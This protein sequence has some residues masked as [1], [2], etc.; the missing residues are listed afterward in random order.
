MTSQCSPPDKCRLPD[1]LT[2]I[3]AGPLSGF[4]GS[5]GHQRRTGL[6]LPNRSAIV[7]LLGAALGIDGDNRSGQEGIAAYGVAVQSLRRSSALR[8]F[9]TVQTI[10]AGVATG[11]KTRT[12]ALC[13]AGEARHNVVTLRDYRSDTAIGVAVWGCGGWALGDLAEA[14][15]RPVYALSLGRRSCPPSWPLDPKIISAS[16]PVA[17]LARVKPA[18]PPESTAG[19]GVERGAV[20][21][22]SAI[23]GR[24]ASRSVEL[25][26]R[27]ENRRTWT[28]LPETAWIYPPLPE[29]CD[30]Q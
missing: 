9:H 30:G 28:F 13:S 8:D 14:L 7:G 4:S 25:H 19:W 1:H 11:A 24:R 23:P 12:D 6:L 27:P 10:P 26:S 21:S 15:C 3:L 5:G 2:F 20:M 16:D 17:A 29:D 22:W 18:V